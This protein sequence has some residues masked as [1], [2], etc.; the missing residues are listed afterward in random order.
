MIVL[1]AML[2]R[3]SKYLRLLGYDLIIVSNELS[4]DS[5]IQQY[6][7]YLI[8]TRDRNLA[9][10]APRSIYVN[11]DIVTEQTK[12]VLPVL[13]KPEHEK[14][15]LCTICGNPLIEVLSRDN[16]PDYVPKDKDRIYYCSKCNKYYWYGSHLRNF[17]QS[18]GKIGIE[19]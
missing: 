7:N 6:G 1:D 9:K 19:I 17:I 18:M 4:D 12:E 16:L 5:I 14:F 10:K 8:L 2:G 3:L 15:S 13:P 11:S